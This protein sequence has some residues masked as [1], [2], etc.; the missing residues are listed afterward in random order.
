MSDG[1]DLELSDLAR[2]R[3]KQKVLN[4]NAYRMGTE[5]VW[6]VRSVCLYGTCC[7]ILIALLVSFGI[8]VAYWTTE[9]KFR[10]DVYETI[11]DITEK[12]SFLSDSKN[13]ISLSSFENLWNGL[14][15]QNL[16]KQRHLTLCTTELLKADSEAPSAALVIASDPRDQIMYDQNAFFYALDFKISLEFGVDLGTYVMNAKHLDSSKTYMTLSYLITSSYLKFS[17]VKLI[18]NALDTRGKALIKTREIILCS[19]NPSLDARPCSGG[20][21]NP[22]TMF[23]KNTK[24]LPMARKPS[25]ILENPDNTATNK[26]RVSLAPPQDRRGKTLPPAGTVA[27]EEE[28]DDSYDILYGEKD[29]LINRYKVEDDFTRDIRIYNVLFYKS[30][31]ETPSSTPDNDNTYHRNKQFKESLAFVVK[32]TKCK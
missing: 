10:H 23:V 28:D 4:D 19:N 18:E 17:T 22:N 29:E 27:E 1:E 9:G 12:N 7:I 30:I 16:I 3:P 15:S 6:T 21:A 11:N 5:K 13:M 14:T 32:P 24:L 8:T 26:S 31:D 25:I 20:G 2:N